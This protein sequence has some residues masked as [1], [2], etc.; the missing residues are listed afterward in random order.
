LELFVSTYISLT[1]I[2]S[3]EQ[4]YD[5]NVFDGL[6]AT[7]AMI[8]MCVIMPILL[9]QSFIIFY[10]YQYL[11]DKDTKLQYGHYYVDL[12]T[13]DGIITALYHVIFIL[14]RIVFVIAMMYFRKHPE[15]QLLVHIISSFAIVVYLV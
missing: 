12:K 8:L 5:Q 10:Y 14:R 4:E 3:F 15:Y 1:P 7:F 6:S 11:D 9:H 2:D 13:R